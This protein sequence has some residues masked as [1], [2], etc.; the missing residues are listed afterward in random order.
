LPDSYGK[1]QRDVVKARKAAARE[2]RRIARR[3]RHRDPGG[4]STLE[5]DAETAF[6]DAPDESG[7]PVTEG[8]STGESAP[9]S[10]DP[11][12]PGQESL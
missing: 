11:S 9:A 6:P 10:D 7:S 5:G 12:G 4:A 2:D 1:R 3:Q 8:D